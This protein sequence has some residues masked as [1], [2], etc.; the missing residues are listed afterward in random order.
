MWEEEYGTCKDVEGR[1]YG[2]GGPSEGSRRMSITVCGG[3]NGTNK[4]GT[5]GSCRL[6]KVQMYPMTVEGEDNYLTL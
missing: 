4:K 6:Y 2:G 5:V 3:E 1:V